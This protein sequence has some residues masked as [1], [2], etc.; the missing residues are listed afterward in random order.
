MKNTNSKKEKNWIIKSVDTQES[1]RA[2]SKISEDL[3]INR[4]V[5]KLLYNRGYTDT[6]SAKSFIY[7]ESEMLSNPFLMKDIEEGIDRISRAVERGEKITVYGD[8]DVDGVT[9]VC[10]LYL[11]LKSVG[12]SVEYYIP[13]RIG[14]GYG[15]STVA[16]DSIAEGGT[17]LIVTVD[18]GITAT[19]E[20]LYA[21]GLGVD[22]V[23]TDHHECRTALPEAVAVI[24]PHRPDCEYPFK[25]LAGVGVV[26][27]FVCAYEERVM[28]TTRREAAKKIFGEYADLVAIG[29]IADVMPIRDENRIIVRY[30]LSKIENN[31]R[32]GLTALM[33][34]ASSRNDLQRSTRSKKRSKITSGY[35]GYTIA[36]RINAAGRIKNASMA[37]E[38]FLSEDP[39]AAREIA[40]EL[41]RTNRERQAEENK[42]MQEASEMISS[43]NIVDNPVIV[44]DADH[45]H[46]GVIGI[47]SSR[48]T[49][50]YSR[51]SI[52][53]S[54]E[55]NEGETPSDEDVGKGSG[56][57][58]KG[59]NLVDALCYCGDHLVKFGGHEL[60]A[61][62]SVK[63]G[64]LD[65]F[66][67]L[68]NEYAKRNL[69]EEDMIP[70]VEADCGIDFEDVTLA[71]AKG[72]QMLEPYGVSNP[73][74]VFVLRDVTVN[75]VTGVSE[76]KHTKFVLGNGKYT[77][78]AMFFSNSPQALGIYTGDKVDVLF[79]ID[80]N[81]WNGRESVQLIIRDIKPSGA[82]QDMAA[83]ERERFEE[84]KSGAP[85]SQNE[86]IMPTRENFVSVYNLMR[87]SLRAGVN[88]L[89]HRDITSKFSAM[90]G[91]RHIGYIKLKIII[92]VLK[93]LNLV[94]LEEISDE[95]YKFDIHYTTAKT[96]L[97]RSTWLRRFRSQIA[98]NG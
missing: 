82:Q 22:F 19:E 98:R 80:I 6:E 1:E 40:E 62:L 42:I 54:F 4:I 68:I 84:I 48:I 83:R 28:G 72:F 64:E 10:T 18:T 52:L 75:E 33:E 66:R 39:D 92:M 7:M 93:E 73:V 85:F 74:P 3:G 25:E 67:R 35:I 47:V 76:S 69:T 88:T 87:S 36:P 8:Y 89:T 77:L 5:A 94:A 2:I 14:E 56:R 51:P 23:I 81:E 11:Y 32:I 20:V 96:D 21:K 63:R 9:A 90:T 43:F 60:A 97:D 61:G 13:N 12:A 31:K 78:S 27:K 24:N 70:T 30:G 53:V 16:I 50:K 71:L 41:C 45:W 46:H 17:K 65:N 79:N 49:E 58:I 95:V 57:S 91:D 34:A 86:N 26:F 15:V 55:G 38:L 44:L 59:M 37:V 29:T